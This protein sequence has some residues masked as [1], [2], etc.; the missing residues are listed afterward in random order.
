M[1]VVEEEHEE[2]SDGE[3]HEDPLDVQVPEID[4]PVAIDGRVE[5]SGVW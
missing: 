4:E 1:V 5:S 2:I 3:G